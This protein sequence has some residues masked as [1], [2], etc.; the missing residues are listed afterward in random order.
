MIQKVNVNT[1]KINPINPRKITAANLKRLQQSL[2][3]F[4]KMLWEG[5]LITVDEDD[6]VL[7]GNQRVKVLQQEI[8]A[9]EPFSWKVVL[10]ENDKYGSLSEREREKIIEYWEK[11]C[12]DP[13][14][15]IDRQ[16]DLTEDQ[17]KEVIIKGN[18]EYGE[19]DFD[20]LGT[21]YDEV[22]LINFG[23]DDAIFYNPDEDPTVVTSIKG[24]RVKKID[25][26]T[27]GKYGVPVTREEY[28]LLRER[29]EEYVDE[30]GVDFGFIKSLLSKK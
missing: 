17:K 13:V 22:D 11:W 23:F 25:M 15:P 19:Y 30:A 8:L 7:R 3:L 26:L 2:M 21:M 29:Y 28:D 18:R 24:S 5:N 27:F 6:F 16:E 14:I 4:P 20:T 9:K 12:K 1:L 10:Q